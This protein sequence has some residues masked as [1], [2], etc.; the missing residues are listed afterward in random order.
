MDGTV[1]MNGQRVHLFSSIYVHLFLQA[2]MQASEQHFHFHI[3]GL[4]DQP[5]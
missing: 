2:T 5:R 4:K 1:Q 3:Q